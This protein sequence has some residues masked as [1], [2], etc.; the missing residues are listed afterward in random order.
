MAQ[1][2][3]RKRSHRSSVRLRCVSIRYLI[4]CAAA[5]AHTASGEGYLQEG[6]KGN[7]EQLMVLPVPR[8][9]LDASG[10]FFEIRRPSQW[11]GGNAIDT[12]AGRQA[13]INQT[14]ETEAI[15]VQLNG[16]ADHEQSYIFRPEDGKEIE[17][18]NIVPVTSNANVLDTEDVDLTVVDVGSGLY[19]VTAAFEFDRSVG[20]TGFALNFVDKATQATTTS[21]STQFTVAGI[22][23]FF[24]N[25]SGSR[26]QIGG[27]RGNLAVS[28][29][30]L[31]Q[32]DKIAVETFVQYLDGSNSST[33]LST[34]IPMSG[35]DLSVS[36]NDGQINFDQNSCSSDGG[37]YDGSTVSLSQACGVGFSTNTVN[38]EYVG[39][40]LG[41]D[42]E[43]NKNGSFVIGFDWDELVGSSDEFSSAGYE[44]YLGVDVTGEVSP[45]VTSISPAGPFSNEGGDTVTLVVE[46][47]PSDSA[48][49]ATW[50]HA[51][52][53]E[54]GT[55]DVRPATL[56]NLEADSSTGLTTLTY[57]LPAG[58]GSDLSWTFVTLKPTGEVLNGVDNTGNFTFTFVEKSNI[59]SLS[60]NTGAT[61][62]GTSV[63]IDGSFVGFDL[64]EANSFITIG[65]TTIDKSLITSASET[66]ITFTTPAESTLAG[67]SG[68]GEYNVAV[69]TDGT[70]SNTQVFTY[71]DSTIAEISPGSGVIAGGTTV[72]VTGTFSN[73]DMSQDDSYITIGTTVIDK[74]LITSATESLIVFTTPAESVLSGGDGNG[75]YPVT[76]TA[77]G[78]TSAPNS[79]VFTDGSIVITNLSPNTGSV[80][81]GSTVTATGSFSGFDASSSSS[82][83]TVGSTVIDKALIVSATESEIVFTSPPETGLSGGSGNGIYGVTI[84]ANGSTSNTQ[85]FTYKEAPVI[86]GLSPTFGPAAGGTI[87]TATGDFSGFNLT[88]AGSFITIGGTAVDKSTISSATSTSI[89]FVTPS[90][91]GLS[92]GTNG[93]FDVVITAGGI[94]S[95]PATFT[96]V[97][98]IVITNIS[99][100]SGAMEG[101]TTVTI[102]G[103]FTGF[104]P[105]SGSTLTVGGVSIPASD[106]QSFSDTS[107]VFTTP[108]QTSLDN[109][110][111]VFRFPVVVT[112]GGQTS[113][114]AEFVYEAPVILTSMTPSSGEEEGG[115]RITL[116]G[117]FVNYNPTTS[118]VFFGGKQ[119][120]GSRVISYTDSQIVLTSPP[121]EDLGSSFSYDVSVLIGDLTSNTLG[122]VYKSDF[123]TGVDFSGGTLNSDGQL[124]IGKCGNTV[125]RAQI[126]TSALSQNATF[127]WDILDSTGTTILAGSDI[128]KT[129]E[130][131][132]V[133]YTTLPEENVVYTLTLNV[134]TTFATDSTSTPLIRLSAQR[135][136][137]RIFDP[138]AV[139]PANPNTTLTIQTDIGVPGCLNTPTFSLD[140]EDVTYTWEY[141]D[142]TFVFSHLNETVNE[143]IVGPSLLGREFKIPQEYMEYGDFTLKLT[144]RYTQ[145]TSIFGSDST[146]VR[147]SPADLVAVINAGQSESLISTE[148]AVDVTGANSWDPDVLTGDQNADL[149]YN[150]TC[151]YGWDTAL[152]SALSCGSSLL[153]SS[154]QRS[155]TLSTSALEGVQNTTKVYIQYSLAVGK[156]SLN[157]TGDFIARQSAVVVSTL[158]L[159][160][161]DGV[162]YEALE[163]ID[164]NGNPTSKADPAQV[165]YFQDVIISPIAKSE[166]TSWTFELVSP[167]SESTLL[168]VADNLITASG[169]WGVGGVAGRTELG[170]VAN[171]LKA[172]TQY[173]FL[174]KSSRD[175]FEEN[176]EVLQLTTMQAPE[177]FLSGLPLESGTTND[178]FVVSAY[179]NYDGDF[180]FYFTITD[181]LGFQSCVDGCQG[182]SLV[183]FRLMSA[184]SYQ[185]R[186]DVYD[187]LGYTLLGSVT[188]EKNITVTSDFG[189]DD[190]LAIFAADLNS[191]FVSGD[192]GDYQQFGT[193]LTKFVLAGSNG[194]T[195]PA[196]DSLILEEFLENFNQIVAN[197]VP[198]SI[199]SAGFVNTASALTQLTP[200]LG[201]TYSTASLYYL[202]NITVNAV[203]RSPDTVALNQLEEL[204]AFYG[205]NTPEIVLAAG[206][207]GT[208]RR[209]LLQTGIDGTGQEKVNILMADFY[210]VM[211]R[212]IAVVALKPIPC[213]AVAKAETAAGSGQPS[214]VSR[215]AA[216][217]RMDWS[218][219]Q[220]EGN[221]T[222]SEEA[223]AAEERK[224]EAAKYVNAADT[225]L[226]SAEWQVAHVCN[227]EQ[228]RALQIAVGDGGEFCRFGWCSEIFE[229]QFKDL[230]FFIA[231]TPNY[232]FLSQIRRNTTL[233][234]GLFSVGA[235]RIAA[236]NKFVEEKAPGDG[237]FSL[238]IPIP[239]ALTV[240]PDGLSD[241]EKDSQLPKPVRISPEKQW[242]V[243]VDETRLLYQGNFLLPQELNISGSSADSTL[244]V[245]SFK[246]SQTGIYSVATRIAWDGGFFSLEGYS[247]T[248]AEV[249]GTTLTVLVLVAAATVGAWLLSSRLVSFIGAAPP[250]EA[251]FTYVERDVYGRGTAID[252]MEAQEPS[253]LFN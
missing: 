109:T 127:A 129:A 56:T 222:S 32:N 60:P 205:G 8:E 33:S 16:T 80:A 103:T 27:D 167:R 65:T 193:D 221:G 228:S 35:I 63:T 135:I 50:T 198:N 157:A 11:G 141:R 186:V 234:D 146:T 142:A 239:K 140:E 248:V 9:A 153:P 19:N 197:S 181:E 101:G 96:Y 18:Y 189:E 223:A 190:S 79:F 117:Q 151:K 156:T 174:I 252:M 5:V 91:S 130:V 69:T 53:I 114:P 168:E 122:Y 55:G 253:G 218:M 183:R 194:S 226:Q 85:L 107:I 46:N 76:I 118:G 43:T 30:D 134:T 217:S 160:Q 66:S 98:E 184:G 64:S 137:V 110:N 185:I 87:V 139:S 94:A 171:K 148:A 240:E 143:D 191:S 242:G 3:A 155:F 51:L 12:V 203:E 236:N 68:N 44:T 249:V 74:S 62:G 216:L 209:R 231:R 213:G 6:T 39:P 59:A 170:I 4:I 41:L 115:E 84:T 224:T 88:D 58:T 102:T 128:V 106:I 159:S 100:E 214:S 119:L 251:D 152:T 243:A 138:D 104:N 233:A 158:I 29:S 207:E 81:G 123:T 192:H 238:D 173:E 215:L 92:G 38:N 42:F 13:V 21:S 14:Q 202:V 188:G 20:Q 71:G 10:N 208:T 70:T 250:V 237:C 164:V 244:S 176:E 25:S 144:A 125:Y 136:G 219:R 105:S 120:D 108:A 116:D 48:I 86:T 175:G 126:P 1:E 97:G 178:T 37:T 31:L 22:S 212:L 72:N 246:T 111:S 57:T 7:G 182:P 78:V 83:I 232:P 36:G 177:V 154:S 196:E 112:V 90:E 163:R 195:S 47:L 180:K 161:E 201:I 179:T 49:A 34:T 204:L 169:Y 113:N 229:E 210:E 145:N 131:F 93:G 230:Y 54:F 211:K 245:V 45:V 124:E 162:K 26:Q 149:S 247:L 121:R 200:Q 187:S 227:P 40:F 147:I 166:E 61:A 133:P 77:N 82:F 75:Q 52:G 67:G 2:P 220:T 24:T 89:T 28:V 235:G 225:S 165:K 206:P 23:F 132:Y 73:V 172:G 15:L 95:E 99:P 199:Q 150:W 17:D 241:S